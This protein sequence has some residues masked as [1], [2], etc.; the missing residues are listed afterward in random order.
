M[1]I[2]KKWRGAITYNR[3]LTDQAVV[4]LFED[5]WSAS[6]TGNHM[7][8]VDYLHFRKNTLTRAVFPLAEQYFVL[9]HQLEEEE[10]KNIFS[11]RA[12]KLRDMIEEIE[13]EIAETCEKPVIWE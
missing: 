6:S 3:K 8:N 7:H 12:E 11:K 9:C 4:C 10:K 1:K 13:Q 2:P 5:G